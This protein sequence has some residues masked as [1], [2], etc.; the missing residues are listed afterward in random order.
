MCAALKAHIGGADTSRSYN[1]P[2]TKRVRDAFQS[3]HSVQRARE[4]TADPKSHV[5]WHPVEGIAPVHA[6]APAPAPPSPDDSEEDEV[7]VIDSDSDDDLFGDYLEEEHPPPHSLTVE[8]VEQPTIWI[9]PEPVRPQ[10]RV[11]SWEAFFGLP[12]VVQ[13]PDPKLAWDHVVRMLRANGGNGQ[14]PIRH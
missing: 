2:A 8:R 11:H 7:H 10:S 5:F 4:A 1:I 14:D 12:T 6:P 3:A 9:D 13:Q